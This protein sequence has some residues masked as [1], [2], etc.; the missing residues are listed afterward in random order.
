MLKIRN[1]KKNEDGLYYFEYQCEGEGTWGNGV[2]DL[3]HHTGSVEELASKDFE[4][5]DFYRRHIHSAIQEAVTDN[6]TE[7]TVAWY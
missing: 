7:G 3:E 6:K 1:L 5:S 2:Y 4:D